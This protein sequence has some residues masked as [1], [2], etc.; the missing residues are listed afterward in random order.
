MNSQIKVFLSTLLF[1][2]GCLI[3]SLIIAFNVNAQTIDEYEII[4]IKSL[5]STLNK[6]NRILY[7]ET[8]KTD[9]ID[10]KHNIVS[11]PDKIKFYYI[12]DEVKDA[13][14]VLIKENEY[15]STSEIINGNTI[16][17]YGR[18][19]F[20]KDENNIIHYIQDAVISESDWIDV[21]AVSIRDK[22]LALF[23]TPYAI[24]Q[25]VFYPNASDGVLE[26]SNTN[27]NTCAS[28]DS[29]AGTNKV[30]ASR[31]QWF[32]LDYGKYYVAQSFYN[33]DVSDIAE[34]LGKNEITA[35]TFN[36]YV[37][38]KAGTGSFNLYQNTV[39]SPTDLVVD[40]FGNYNTTSLAT[41]KS[42]DDMTTSAYNTWTGNQDMIDLIDTTTQWLQLALVNTNDYLLGNTA[43]TDAANFGIRFSEYADTSSDPYL[44][45]TIASS[46]PPEEEAST[47]PDLF[48]CEIPENNDIGI[49]TGCKNIYNG[50]T[51]SSTI[52]GVEY[53]YYDIKFILYLFILSIIFVCLSVIN[54]FLKEKENEKKKK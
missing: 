34:V 48:P 29:V 21:N 5:V 36:I 44:Q 30:D 37:Y 23:K 20:Y 28:A 40:D 27:F 16:K 15:Y 52:T 10:E 32:G 51:S 38:S 54:I 1:L 50:T 3:V 4:E 18:P 35:L 7:S 43:P 46:T 12:A 8:L 11:E 39:S 24:A 31:T 17:K 47:T 41:A 45:F 22:V 25:T 49:I 33:F 19:A 42:L 9:E 13:K 14:T 26:N 53:F 2:F 6:D